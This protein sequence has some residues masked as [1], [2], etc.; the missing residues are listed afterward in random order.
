MNKPLVG[1]IGGEG[2]MGVWFK[3]LFEGKGLTVHISDVGTE[4]TARDIAKK[5]QVVIISVPIAKTE[6]II[7]ETG[8]YVR[9]DGLL[10]DLTSV[11][12]MPLRAMLEHSQCEVVGAHPL[13]GPNET[14]IKGLG[15]ALCPGRGKKWLAWIKELLENMGARVLITSP[16][17]HDRVMATVQGLT[18]SS[19]LALA[20]A[21]NETGHDQHELDTFTTTSFSYL[22]TQIA[23]TLGQNADL[24]GQILTLNTDILKTVSI[25]EAQVKALKE[26]IE[27]GDYEECSDLIRRTQAGL[28]MGTDDGA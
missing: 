14:S 23:R 12:T 3:N 6:E 25:L 4:L 11:K 21:I 17:Y 8:P 20:M 16:E 26:I 10:M 28:G 1:I 18:H 7:S 15:M 2:R 22:R 24:I 27:R 13:F 19:I 9:P 5:C